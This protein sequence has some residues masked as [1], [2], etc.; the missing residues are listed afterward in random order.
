M[1]DK[2]KGCPISTLFN[3]YSEFRLVFFSFL[4]VFLVRIF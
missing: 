2:Q 3:I 4:L 1:P